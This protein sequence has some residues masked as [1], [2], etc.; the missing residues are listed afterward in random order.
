M[1]THFSAAS[2]DPTRIVILGAG[3]FIGGALA[4]EARRKG[5][6]VLGLG[7]SNFSLLD[8]D[9]GDRLASV[10][11][12]DDAVVAISAQ[13]PCKTPDMVVDNVR[14]MAA[15]CAALQRQPVAHIV[16]ISSDAVYADAP[17]PLNETSP[18]APTSLHGAMHLARELMLQ[19]VAA[20]TPL[21]CLRPTLVYGAADPHDGYGPNKFRRLANSGEPILLFGEGEERRDHVCIQDVAALALLVLRHR[22]AGVLNV[23]TGTVTSFRA[24]ADLAVKLAGKDVPIRPQPRR[25]PMPHG[26]YRPFDPAATFA[27][28]PRFRYTVIEDGMAL[29]QREEFG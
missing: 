4:S 10:L 26:G 13:A 20:A 9:A 17:L 21:A 5:L 14:I 19:S 7:R 3:G 25:G 24:A 6:N 22:S 8:A 11:K 12:P 16:Y 29:A 28:F 15:I 1:L 23:A 27:A 2:A 18:A